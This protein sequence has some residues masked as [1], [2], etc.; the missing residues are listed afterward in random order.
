MFVRIAVFLVLLFTG[1]AY[2]AVLCGDNGAIFSDEGLCNSLCSVS[3]SPVNLKTTGSSGVCDTTN[4]QGFVYYNNKTYALSKTSDFWDSFPNLAVISN[5]DI[6]TLLTGIL[7]YF[8]I[9]AWI[10][11]YDP[12]FTPSFNTVDPT[13][14]V[15]RNGLN[16][17]FGN[18]AS[19]EPDNFLAS[20]DIGTVTI[21]G[22]HWVYMDDHGYWYDDGHHKSY[23]GDFKPKRF[24]L[25]EWTGAL[26]CV[27]AEIPP[28]N[29]T[30]NIVNNVCNGTTPCYVCYTDSGFAQCDSGIA[31]FDYRYRGSTV[32]L[33]QYEGQIVVSAEGSIDYC[34]D[35]VNNIQGC[36]EDGINAIK[37]WIVFIGDDGNYYWLGNPDS[38]P[39]CKGSII[40]N[41]LSYTISGNSVTIDIPSGVRFIQLSDV[42]SLSGQC[43]GDN[44]YNLTIT[45]QPA[46]LCPQNRVQ[47]D[48]TNEVPL[49]PE[50]TLNPD[51]DMCQA[52]AQINC[53]TGYIWDSSIDRCIRDPECSDGGIFNSVTDRCEKSF[54][55]VCPS[56][57]T[58]DLNTNT[59]YKSVDCGIGSFN[60]SLDRCEYPM[61]PTCPAGFTLVNNRCEYSPPDCPTGT[62]YSTTL[63]LCIAD[64]TN[65]CPAGYTW[66]GSRCETSPQ[67]PT[68]FSYNPS[69][70]RCEKPA[71]RNFQCP[72]GYFYNSS[73][74]RCETT[75]DYQLIANIPKGEICYR[76]I[77]YDCYGN[78]QDYVYQGW[79]VDTCANCSD[80]TRFILTNNFNGK[81]VLTYDIPDDARWYIKENGSVVKSGGNGSSGARGGVS[82]VVNGSIEIYVGGDYPD[83]NPGVKLEG[84][85]CPSWA[86]YSNSLCVTSPSVTLSCPAGSSLSG[87]TCIANP[88]C[89]NGGN[90]D[91]NADVCWLNA[92]KICP[93]GTTLNAN[94]NKCTANAT[95]SNSA[96]LDT[97]RDVC[98]LAYT[99]TCPTD[100]IYDGTNNVCYKAVTCDFVYNPNRDRCEATLDK[101]CGTYTLDTV[102]NICFKEV[103]CQ[104]DPNFPLNSTITFDSGLDKCISEAEH[105]C[106]SG[107]SYTYTWNSVPVN[108][109]ELIPICLNGSYN[110][111]NDLCYLGDFSCPLGSQYQCVTLSDGKNYC[112]DIFCGDT[113]Y[114]NNF[115]NTDTPEG[116]NDKQA[117]GTV[118]SSGNCLGTIY[119]FNGQDKRCRPPGTQ[120][121][122][123]DCCKDDTIDLTGLVELGKCNANEMYLAKLREWGE[124][125]GKCH[126]IGEYC[127]ERWKFPGGSVCVQKKKTFCCFSSPLARIIQEQGREQLGISWGTPRSPN[128]RG[129]TP[130]EFQKLDWNKIDFSEWIE[131]EVI[132]SIESN[133][134][135]N[136]EKTIDQIKTNIETKY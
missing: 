64:Y 93:A 136:I 78:A 128:C 112:S 50:G 95:C 70:N 104:S 33:N 122:Y 26:D 114:I 84:Y 117:D 6:N 120:T 41:T 7:S 108:K 61:T 110:P 121:Y 85:S 111:D 10:G 94:L 37:S 22:E 132:P 126:Y 113:E 3:C 21:Y 72:P 97:T 62:T 81:L 65:S 46:Y 25:V 9:T 20:D 5:Q 11:L 79:N 96:S 30:Q 31:T 130:E 109:C 103:F 77:Y 88:S 47:C 68:G 23:G 13:R 116:I 1:S 87:S 59:C 38:S 115:E 39:V 66:T 74:N 55:P 106:P 18:W 45:I 129:F 100:W 12:D 118:D 119:I 107:S 32:E 73:T 17:S 83:G 60:P 56:G 134:T 43:T 57:Y 90:F 82:V 2:T 91:G 51:R 101:D 24:A 36:P 4:Y 102:N 34:F 75:A 133:L 80:F 76:S 14:F 131:G 52:D 127:A 54:T 98:W 105:I 92:T 53:P 69:T 29:S 40:L 99:P 15:W 44:R 28:E 123:N 124:R 58:A 49:C 86:T 35:T 27:N 125:D 42:E 8:N 19:N 63:D 71:N 67:C 16:I 135:S 48:A 89:P